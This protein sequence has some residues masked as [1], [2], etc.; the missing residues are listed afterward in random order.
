MEFLVIITTIKYFR[1]QIS[2]HSI[3]FRISQI[4]QQLYQLLQTL[5]TTTIALSKMIIF[6]KIIIEIS[7]HHLYLYHVPV[8]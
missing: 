4:N 1:T 3:V 2:Q 7:Q 6:V 8:L 5:I